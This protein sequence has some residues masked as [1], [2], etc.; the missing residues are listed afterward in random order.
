[1]EIPKTHKAIVYKSPGTLETEIV[2]VETPRPGRGEVLI[3]LQAAAFCHTDLAFILNSYGH[4]PE[5][6]PVNQIG[7]H[8]GVGYVVLSGE[9]VT[10]VQ[11]GDRVGVKWITS[12]C[13]TCQPCMDGFD[14]K[15][16]KRKVAGFKTPGTFQQYI[17]TD[18]RYATPIPDG[19]SSAAAAPL[20]CGGVTVW[21]ALVEANCKL[22]NWLGISGAGGGLGHLAVQYGKALGLRVLAIDHGSKKDYCLEIGADAFVDFTQFNDDELAAQ[23]KQVTDGGCHSLLVCNASSRAYDQ[24]L[25]LLRYAGTLVC[26]GIPERDVHPIKGTEP[27]KIITGL[28]KIKGAV[29]GNRIQAVECLQ[30]AAQGIV[31]PSLRIEPMSKLTQIF[32]DL[33]AGKINGRTVL[34]LE[35]IA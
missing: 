18:P 19:L 7:G 35:Q 11:V 32:E 23:V 22:G 14:N 1:M 25:D 12:A 8:E 10:E 24:A 4:M 28:Y 16:K 15:C 27:W 13:L 17:V 20:L 3:R 29:T 21:S 6:T 33:K 5:P 26:V 9:G 2:D 30:P 31:R 34:D